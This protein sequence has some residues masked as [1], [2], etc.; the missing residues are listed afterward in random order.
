MNAAKLYGVILAGGKGER[1]W[2]LS[3]QALPKQFLEIKNRSLLQHTYDRLTQL[4]DTQNI[5]VVTI[6]SQSELIDQHLPGINCIVEPVS[7]NTGPALL[8]SCLHIAQQDPEAIILFCPADHYIDQ[9]DLFS[10][11]FK[12]AIAVSKETQQITLLG[13]KPTFPATG[14][15]YIEYAFAE[16]TAVQAPIIRFHEKPSATIAQKY[17]ELENMLWNIGIFCAPVAVF[18][19]AYKQYA[20]KLFRG[21][22]KYFTTG[23]RSWYEELPSISVDYAIMEKSSA[24]HV[25]PAHFTWSDIG[26][27]ATYLSLE[28]S[29]SNHIAIESVNNLVKSSKPV[30]VLIGVEDLVIVQTDDVLLIAQRSDTEKVKAAVS[31]LRKNNML[32]YL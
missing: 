22:S 3:T 21:V 1:L 14:Y 8:I 23:E 25:I 17:M 6:Q 4:I 32:D 13:V 24:L 11:S 5:S 7:K 29:N 9:L 27:L 26:N 15:G 16:A 31:E 28:H 18:I 20:P 10:D 12:H 2:P 19:G 30:T